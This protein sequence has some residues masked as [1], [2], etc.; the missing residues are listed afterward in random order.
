MKLKKWWN[1]KTLVVIN[2]IVMKL[3]ELKLWQ[4]YK[5]QFVMKLK[6]SNCDKIIKINLWQKS[7]TQIVT[8]LKLW[9]NSICDKTQIVTKPKLWKK[10]KKMRISRTDAEIVLNSKSEFHQAPLIRVVATNGLQEEQTSA[11]SQGVGPGRRAG[12]GGRGGGTGPWTCSLDR[13]GEEKSRR[14]E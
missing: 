11:L 2:Q 5:T 8:K 3:N 4:N 1:S 14:L 9:Q 6:N 7:K 13:V 10:I 12:Q